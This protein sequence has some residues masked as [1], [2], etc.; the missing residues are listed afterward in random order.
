MFFFFFSSFPDTKHPHGHGPPGRHARARAHTHAHMHAQRL[1]RGNWAAVPTRRTWQPD[2][3]PPVGALPRGS[4]TFTYSSA[5]PHVAWMSASCTRYRV[6]SAS[7]ECIFPL[8]R[9][10]RLSAPHCPS[11]CL[12]M[13]GEL[14]LI[15]YKI[16][17][18]FHA[19]RI[20]SKINE[21]R[22]C[23]WTRPLGTQGAPFCNLLVSFTE[24]HFQFTS[25]T[26]CISLISLNGKGLDAIWVALGKPF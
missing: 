5:A 24:L 9:G 21:K 15:E 13:W 11:R 6:I 20:G 1:P 4:F 12:K 14:F 23:I 19:D 25:K 22:L 7:I 2:A 18:R 3:R 17:I 8:M 26:G 16:I 10:A